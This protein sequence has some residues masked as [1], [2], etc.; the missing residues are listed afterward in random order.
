MAARV[1]RHMLPREMQA[2]NENHIEPPAIR[3]STS[4][5]PARSLAACL[6]ERRTSGNH[7]G[8]ESGAYHQVRSSTHSR[9]PSRLPTAPPS[10]LQPNTAR[11]TRTSASPT[12]SAP[13]DDSGEAA[14]AD[15]HSPTSTSR[16][17]TIA[18]PTVANSR[19]GASADQRRAECSQS[20][21]LQRKAQRKHDSTQ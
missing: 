3:C 20:S 18:S 4:T 7:G 12:A 21:D 6:S 2:A 16:C 1:S 14:R 11:P 9:S 10:Q 19:S 15:K 5:S 8:R 13:A 17:I